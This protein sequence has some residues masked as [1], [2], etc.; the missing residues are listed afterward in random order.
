[1]LETEPA[2]VRK[3][4]GLLAQGRRLAATHGSSGAAGAL[5]QTHGSGHEMMASHGSGPAGGVT[6]GSAAALAGTSWSMRMRAADISLVLER[7]STELKHVVQLALGQQGPPG[8]AQGTGAGSGQQQQAVAGGHAGDEDQYHVLV[9]L[10]PAEE[11][12]APAAAAGG[13]T[14]ADGGTLAARGS[15]GGSAT[16]TGGGGGG[17]EDSKVPQ[18]LRDATKLLYVSRPSRLVV[19]VY[20]DSQACVLTGLARK[21]KDVLAGCVTEVVAFLELLLPPP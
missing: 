11:S 9:P 6:H 8:A 13:S 4:I 3:L 20:A 1:M 15:G 18:A 14:D 21:G 16:A 19:A 7:G 2:A 10:A 12:S 5:A 17:G